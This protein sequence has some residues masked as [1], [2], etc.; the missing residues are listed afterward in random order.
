MLRV[1]AQTTEATTLGACPD[2]CFIGLDFAW[3]APSGSPCKLCEVMRGAD[4][5][6]LGTHFLDT[7]RA[8]NWR[9]PL[10]C[11]ICPNTGSTICF[12]N[13]SADDLSSS[14]NTIEPRPF[15]PLF[16]FHGSFTIILSEPQEKLPC[17]C[18]A[19][20]F[21]RGAR[22]AFFREPVLWIVEQGEHELNLWRRV[23]SIKGNGHQHLRSRTVSYSMILVRALR[24]NRPAGLRTNAG[25]LCD[26]FA[27]KPSFGSWRQEFAVWTG[28]ARDTRS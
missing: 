27:E 1:A 2:S 26:L 19:G 20:G 9:N 18:V 16:G 24:K 23:N 6:P 3:L 12:L 22:L 4:H 14:R 28:V 13:R 5:R 17:F 8:K 25:S 7:A 10:A 11:L 15:V 21:C